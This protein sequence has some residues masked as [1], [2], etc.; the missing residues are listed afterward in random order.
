[1]QFDAIE[2]WKNEEVIVHCRSGVRSATACA[3]M[4]QAGFTN[5]KNLKGG[6]IAWQALNA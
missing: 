3:I 2:N 6:I 5:V 4:Q 1:M